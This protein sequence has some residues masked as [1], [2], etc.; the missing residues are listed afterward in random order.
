MAAGKR[1]R[2]EPACRGWSSVCARGAGC[3]GAGALSK[4]E[5][6]SLQIS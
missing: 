6:V 2:F 1:E 4:D 3:A 5:T